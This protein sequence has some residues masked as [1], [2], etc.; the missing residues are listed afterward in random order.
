MNMSQQLL[1]YKNS[2]RVNVKELEAVAMR[3]KKSIRMVN[4]NKKSSG[5]DLI[6]ANYTQKLEAVELQLSE[7]Q[8]ALEKVERGDYSIFNEHVEQIKQKTI[9]RHDQEGTANSAKAQSTERRQKKR[10]ATYKKCRQENRSN[11]WDKKKYIIYY[12]KFCRAVD[13]IPEYMIDNLKQMPNNKGYLWRGITVL[14]DKKPVKGEPMML[15]EKRY[16]VLWIHKYH[17]CKKI[18]G[19]KEVLL[20]RYEKH[21]KPRN[22]QAKIEVTKFLKKTDWV[23]PPGAKPVEYASASSQRNRGNNRGGNRRDNRGG[24]RRDSRGG[25]RR[26]NR[27]DNRGNN[28]RNQF[29]RA[30][31]GKK[32]DVSSWG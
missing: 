30:K 22:G 28:N 23:T 12:S 9:E 18:I 29:S 11:R 31:T 10:D 24:N 19:G 14:G 2:I 7:Q 17:E 32:R 3:L 4:K 1:S 16:G 15:F 20:W 21:K 26:D 25:N 6:L 5:N 27:G 8:D 13:S